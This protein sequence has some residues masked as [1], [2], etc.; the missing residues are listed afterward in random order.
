MPNPIKR[1]QIFRASLHWWVIGFA[2]LISFYL[3]RITDL[4]PGVQLR[5]PPLDSSETMLFWLFAIAIFWILAYSYKIYD[6]EIFLQ[7]KQH[8]SQAF[9]PWISTLS[10][11]AYLGFG[12][13]FI[14]GISRFILVL[15]SFLSIVFILIVEQCR[16]YLYSKKLSSIQIAMYGSDSNQVQEIIYILTQES[17]YQYHNLSLKGFQTKFHASILVGN[18]DNTTLQ[19]WIDKGR[20]LWTPFFHIPHGDHIEHALAQPQRFWPL[21]G[22]FVSTTPLQHRGG[23]I[24]R[25]I[26]ILGS[27]IWLLLLSPLF[28]LIAIAIKLESSWPVIYVQKRVWRGTTVFNFVKFR[29][30]YLQDCI[31]DSY[32]GAQARTKR[33]QLMNSDKNVRK[34]ILQKIQDDPRVTKVGKFLRKTSLDELASLWNVFVGEMS[35]VWP[36][37]HMPHEVAQYQAWHK[38]LLTIKP[39][40]TG[41]A[42]LYGRDQVPFDEEAKLDLRYIQ[43]RS[44]ALDCYILLA[45]C[46]VL[47]KGR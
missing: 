19:E 23:V 3:R 39:G 25:G 21:F 24:K 4:I 46:K 45:T 32:G 13:L 18:Y 1:F 26:D 44:F 36:R 33:Q 35:L 7:D 28:L 15:A 8:I 31:W 42:Q 22:W 34:G 12:F 30:M 47:V 5:I 41:Y 38:R 9:L 14:W 43:H 2:F 20:W 40:I 10:C 11:L 6:L 29:S 17:P 16:S 27:G 37:P